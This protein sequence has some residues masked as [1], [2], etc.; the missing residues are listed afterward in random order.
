MWRQFMV[1]AINF[2]YFELSEDS[3]QIYILYI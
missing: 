1:H 2:N 3:K